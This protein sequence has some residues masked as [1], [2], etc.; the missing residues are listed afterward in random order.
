MQWL[1]KQRNFIDF[2][3]SSLL[4]RKGKNFSLLFVY[5]L[6]IFL[7]SSVMFFASSLRSQATELLS[8][9]PE[10]IVQKM[11]AGRQ[12]L[13]PLSAAEEIKRIRG[14][15]EVK[16]RFWGYY[17]HPAS[18]SNYTIMASDSFSHAED[19]AV[20][21]NGVLRSWGTVE[22]NQL[23]FKTYNG[24]TMEL[25]IADKFGA[26][27]DLVSSDLILVSSAAFKKLFGTPP[28]LATDLG[29]TVRNLTECPKIAEKIN[30][31]MPDTRV[32]EREQILRTYSSIFDWR[33]GY[34]IVL[35]SGAI[36]A[37]FIFA[38]EKATGLS[39]EER[40][41]IGILKAVGWDTAEILTM[42]FWEGCVISLTAF[43][44]GVT[45]A[46]IHVFFASAPLFEHALKGWSV[47]Y[48]TFQLHPSV[49]WYQLG[50]LFLLTVLP[51]AL[52]TI[53]PVWKA[54]IIDP[55]AAM[56]QT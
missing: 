47:M 7:I 3:L 48:P 54:S 27:T 44:L 42:K 41:E 9:A 53:I 2:T 33:S 29:V 43:V 8:E 19:E 50:T 56:R 14:V 30:T 38:W 37:F 51:Y 52:I 20:I 11:V 32:I 40:M 25:A 31:M 12:T 34:V 24:E 16:G 1:E 6:L 36:C 18:G 28:D 21:G 5:A 26:S 55:D 10:M 22:D 23:Y 49:G 45:A 13:I 4:R 39:A 15:K 35:L 17:F 46:Y